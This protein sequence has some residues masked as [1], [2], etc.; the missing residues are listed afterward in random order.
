[1][2]G[3]SPQRGPW[4]RDEAPSRSWKPFSSWTSNESDNRTYKLQHL[5]K[6]ISFVTAL[7]LPKKGVARRQIL[8]LP[9]TQQ[10]KRTKAHVASVIGANVCL[11]HGDEIHGINSGVFVAEHQQFIISLF[12]LCWVTHCVQKKSLEYSRHNFDKFRHNTATSLCGDDVISDVIKNAV[13]RQRRTF[14]KSFPKGK[15]RHCKSIVKRICEQELEWSR[16]WL[17]H[18]RKKVDKLGSVW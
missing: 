12:N 6:Y 7:H 18:F 2:W 4:V 11:G 9:K 13:Y 8:L 5:A 17:S 3:P 16:R 15:T 14:N 1:V 10:P